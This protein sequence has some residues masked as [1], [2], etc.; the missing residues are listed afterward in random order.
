MMLTVIWRVRG[1]MAYVALSSSSKR[2]EAFR[3]AQYIRQNLQSQYLICPMFRN[4]VTESPSKT[5][6]EEGVKEPTFR[7]TA[8][9][10]SPRQQALNLFGVGGGGLADVVAAHVGGGAIVYLRPVG[11]Q[12]HYAGGLGI[13]GRGGGHHLVGHVGPPHGPQ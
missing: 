12:G 7:L 11:E 2:Y 9:R 13:A 5:A 1:A 4:H 8:S 3:T 10:L 6:D